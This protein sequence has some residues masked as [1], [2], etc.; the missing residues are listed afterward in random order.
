MKT[1]KLTSVLIFLIVGFYSANSK[2]QDC[3]NIANMTAPVA[4]YNNDSIYP[5]GSTLLNTGDLSLIKTKTGSWTAPGYFEQ[6]T[7]NNISPTQLFHHGY[8]TFDV[9]SATYSCKKLSIEGFAEKMIIGND[10][11]VT[12]PGFN[13]YNGN[14][15][16]IDT[17]AGGGFVVTGNFNAVTTWVPTGI[18]TGACV[19]SC[20]VSSGNCL[21]AN[22]LDST[23]VHSSSGGYNNDV[24]YPAGSVLATQGDIKFIKTLGYNSS[25]SPNTN[26]GSVGGGMVLF[27]GTITIDVSASSFTCKKLSFYGDGGGL[28]TIYAD[29]DTALTRNGYTVTQIATGHYEIEGNFNSITFSD[30]STSYFNSVC[31]EDCS[32]SSACIDFQDT[33]LHKTIL[34]TQS[35]YGTPW[36]SKNGVS[37]SSKYFDYS[38]IFNNPGTVT[39]DDHVTAGY[40]GSNGSSNYVGN[41]FYQGDVITQVDFSGL[42]INPKNIEFDVNYILNSSSV[43]PYFINGQAL[44]NLPAG[45]TYTAT[46]LTNGFHI[47]ITGNVNTIE[48][49]GFEVGVD[50]MCVDSLITNSTNCFDMNASTFTDTPTNY[51]NDT[52]YPIGSPFVTLGD[53]QIIKTKTGAWMPNFEQSTINQ[54]NANDIW[55]HGYITFDVSNSSYVCRKLTVI[56]NASKVII[57]NDTILTAPGF[58]PYVGNGYV[59]DT[60]SGGYVVTGNFNAVTLHEQTSIYTSVCLEDCSVSN[61]GCIDFQ[62]TLMGVSVPIAQ[63]NYGAPFYSNNGVT[64]RAKYFDYTMMNMPGD[65][66]IA[67]VNTTGYGNDN[68]N[69][70]GNIFFQGNVITQ[71]D[72]TG[73]AIAN[74][75][76]EFDI[77]GVPNNSSTNPYYINGFPLNSLPAGVTYSYTALSAGYHV[78]L[79]GNINTIEIHG[80]E[81]AIDNI[82]VDS[83]ASPC[84]NSIGFTYTITNNGV[85]FT[86]TS[87]HT[88]ATADQFIWD[89]GDGNNSGNNNPLHNYTSP[90]TYY[91][92]LTIVDWNCPNPTMHLCDTIVI[93]GCPNGHRIITP[94]NDGEADEVFIPKGSKIYDRNGF[95]VRK[96]MQDVNWKGRDDNNQELPMG[97]YTVTCGNG[98]GVFNITIVK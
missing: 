16:T 28:T 91:V 20:S 79:T 70:V 73:I 10:T 8:L 2:A 66:N 62:D 51:N 36:Y 9:S 5:I 92:C 22:D 89:F 11:I 14:G 12:T 27:W 48:I 38:G 65:V 78:V 84:N 37:F 68:P 46:P 67:D 83:A 88:P 41:I 23:K 75:K 29:N 98:D 4:D 59:V 43:N 87:S 50:N 31:L 15:F 95:L 72:F 97:Y 45:V 47:T 44:N 77:N 71:I 19:E 81:R 1:I 39:I 56:G 57:G 30:Q 25:I 32:V 40:T 35:S 85:Q 21:M 26:I 24:S 7:F 74:K 90:G 60:V 34:T 82:C 54:I 63:T 58:N 64:F 33:T 96:I 61:S 53:I 6:T 49:H 42:A 55:Y 3:L 18:L 17:L 52:T 13:P 69:Y 80:F 76:I 86:N 93:S 94:N